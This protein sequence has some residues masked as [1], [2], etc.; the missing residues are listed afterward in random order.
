VTSLLYAVVPVL[1]LATAAFLVV[2]QKGRDPGPYWMP[3]GL[4]PARA[5]VRQAMR[6]E[7]GSGGPVVHQTPEHDVPPVTDCCSVPMAELPPGAEFSHDERDVTCGG[8][9]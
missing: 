7:Y 4:D 3:R 8:E 6:G 2:R 5:V 1:I 9:A